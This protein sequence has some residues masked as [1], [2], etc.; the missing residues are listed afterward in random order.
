[1]PGFQRVNPL[2][3]GFIRAP[4]RLLVCPYASTY[5]ADLAQI[6]QMAATSVSYVPEIQT[7]STTGTPPWAL[8]WND[9]PTSRP[10][11][12][13]PRGRSASRNQPSCSRSPRSSTAKRT[14]DCKSDST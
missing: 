4:A 5:P 2:G 10:L 7:I 6:I 9:W 14:T 12:D 1:M 3:E 11:R 8:S 13:R